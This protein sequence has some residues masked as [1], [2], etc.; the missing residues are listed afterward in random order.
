MQHC[1]VGNQQAIILEYKINPLSSSETFI[2]EG[3]HY[4]RD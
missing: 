4:D 1:P 2:R 3:D